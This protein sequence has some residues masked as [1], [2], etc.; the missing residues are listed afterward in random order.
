MILGISTWCNLALCYVLTVLQEYVQYWY[1]Y[2]MLCLPPRLFAILNREISLSTDDDDSSKRCVWIVTIKMII[3]NKSNRFEC[4][5]LSGPQLLLLADEQG[6][7]PFNMLQMYYPTIDTLYIQYLDLTKHAEI[8]PQDAAESLSKYSAL[9]Y[10]L[11]TKV[12]D[13]P[14]RVDI[15][16][17]KKCRF[18]RIC[19]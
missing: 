8:V 18:G 14:T 9:S 3:S 5:S 17:G 19:I 2:L 4:E 7:I 11:I 12:I 13:I 16:T 1:I 15:R 6:R 10:P